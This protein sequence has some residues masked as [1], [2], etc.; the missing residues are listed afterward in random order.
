M[1][2]RKKSTYTIYSLMNEIRTLRRYVKLAYTSYQEGKKFYED[3][4][5]MARASFNTLTEI[6]FIEPDEVEE[7][8]E[9]LYHVLRMYKRH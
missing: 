8:R 6:N 7:L 9:Q 4:E 5:D 3:F 2:E 1:K